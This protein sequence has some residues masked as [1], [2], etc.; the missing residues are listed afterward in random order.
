V[1]A[2]KALGWIRWVPFITLAGLPGIV[3]PVMAKLI[4]LLDDHFEVPVLASG[5]N[6][7]TLNQ[8]WRRADI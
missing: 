4:A 3:P 5:F 7:A 8:R 2:V 6:K 1:I